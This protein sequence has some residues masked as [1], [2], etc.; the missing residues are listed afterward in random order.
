[1]TRPAFAASLVGAVLLAA[2]GPAVP[3][4]QTY[5]TVYGRVYDTATNAPVPG[6]VITVDVV[7]GAT[8]GADGSYTI[9]NVPVG[10]T[11]VAVQ[12]P[13]GYT[14]ANAAALEGFSVTAGERFQLDI[15][16]TPTP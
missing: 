13:A 10:Q 12:V 5:A 9:D 8:S 3:N 4:A 7:D 15:P 14:L 11:D 1:M 6:V 16:L 2:C